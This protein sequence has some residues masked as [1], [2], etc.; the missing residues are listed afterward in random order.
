MGLT[1]TNYLAL[2]TH[3]WRALVITAINLRGFECL[4]DRQPL[5]D[6]LPPTTR[7]C[8]SPLRPRDVLTQG[9][10]NLFRNGSHGPDRKECGAETT[11][12]TV[13]PQSGPSIPLSIM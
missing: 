1:E 12:S 4:N 10:V 8:L 3:Q 11:T 7:V 13:I 5:K 2:A 6:G 9:D